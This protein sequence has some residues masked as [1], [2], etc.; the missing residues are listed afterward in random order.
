MPTID[1][2]V[3]SA[4]VKNKTADNLERMAE[5]SGK[6]TAKV[7]TELVEN[8]ILGNPVQEE[9][10]YPEIYSAGMELI[11]VFLENGFPEHE[12]Y[13]TIERI[14]AQITPYSKSDWA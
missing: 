1:S 9:G 7:L 6:T 2:R 12:I 10:V 14:K 5:I 11:D 13:K 8:A 3:I 4:R